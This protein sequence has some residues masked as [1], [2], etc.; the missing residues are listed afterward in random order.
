[1]DL[2]TF[3]FRPHLSKKNSWTPGFDSTAALLSIHLWL[4]R[5]T[6]GFKMSSCVASII[7]LGQITCG[8]RL[9]T[10]PYHLASPVVCP[11]C[12]VQVPSCMH[13][14]QASKKSL[15]LGLKGSEKGSG[16]VHSS[17]N[18]IWEHKSQNLQ[19]VAELFCVVLIEKCF[20]G[21]LYL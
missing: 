8:V 11:H 20:S 18:S 7:A 14:N 12:I 4:S 2:R 21:C 6:L 17:A 10:P 16:R 9:G 13:G 3:A 15:H 19:I 1:M 5:L